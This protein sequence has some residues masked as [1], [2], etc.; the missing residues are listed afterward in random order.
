[1]NT[2]LPIE[3]SGETLWLLPDK[4]IYWPARRTL[5]VADVH[6]GK[7]AS[8]R[9][10][11]QPVPRGTTATTLAR[12]DRLLT[13]YDCEQLIILGDFFHSRAAHSPHTL[14]SLQGWISRHGALKVVLVRGN[15][16]RHAGDPP[17]ELGI[18]VR[19]EPLLLEPFA[20]QHEPVAHPSHPVLA[21][22]VHPVY[23]LRGRA[24]QRLRLPCFLIDAQVS[25]LPAFGEFT[26]GWL[27][28]PGQGTRVFLAG[29]DQVWALAN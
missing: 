4:A 23:M 18:E 24:R 7:A 2:Y 5:L 16:D 17:A 13:R 19:D 14:A 3:H 8:Y 15:H 22:H 26:G 6:I 28:E 20:L 11:H 27:V 9:L 10:L 25:L 1:M 29:G 21:G 12:L